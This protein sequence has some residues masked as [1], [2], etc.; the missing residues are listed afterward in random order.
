MCRLCMEKICN[1]KNTKFPDVLFIH[2]GIE[3]EKESDKK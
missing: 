1:V 2:G 3:M